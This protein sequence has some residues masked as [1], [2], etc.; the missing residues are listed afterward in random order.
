MASTTLQQQELNPVHVVWS[1]YPGGQQKFISCPVK[2]IFGEG[3]RGG[4]KTDT[5]IMTFL[6]EVGVGHGAAWTGVL[7]RREYKHL[8]DVV[9]KCKRWIPQ[10]FPDAR[11]LASKGDYKWVFKTGEELLLRTMKDADDYW[12]FHGHEYP[13]IAWEELTNWPTDDCYEVMKSCNRC[14][15]PG[16]QKKYLST[17]N[18]FGAG[19]GWVKEYFIDI[20]AEGTVKVDEQ[21]NARVRIHIDLDD[22]PA[23]LEND[24]DYVKSLD[25]I[26]NPE[27]RK[28]WREGDWDIVVGG[29]LQGIWDRKKH[30][31]KPFN[32]PA[33]WPRWRAGDWGFAAP[34]SIGWYTISPDGV[35]YRYREL[36]G[37]GGKANKGS[38]ESAPDVAA[39]ML[40]LEKIERKS[41]IEFKRNPMDSS[42][43]SNIGAEITIEELFRKAG[44]RW[45]KTN[46]AKGSRVNGAQV[47]MNALE[48]GQF[49][50]FDTCEHWLRTVPVLMPDSNN[51]EDVDT[52]MEDHAWDETRYSLTSRHKVLS[53]EM[54]KEE[55][56]P[57][58]FDHMIQITD[59]QRSVY[60]LD[61]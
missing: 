51:W 25:G 46:K 27:L 32:I 59:K 50:V 17:G 45:V 52:E 2:E 21:G 16:I 43:W 36:Y 53:R 41:G 22:N 47:I 35:I 60:S 42:I 7:F 33:D 44:V 5:L 1:P 48:N 28:A 55:P 49:K 30:V 18:P 54:K 8:D 13:W 57:G 4:G 26:K 61:N 34:Y 12:S 20:G 38:R 24:P 58:T 37:Y 9:K 29:F 23:I 10:L 3:N 19:H 56:K 31:V 40:A 6:K 15:V 11:W 39:K 14:S